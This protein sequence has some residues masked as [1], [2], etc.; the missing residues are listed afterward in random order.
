MALHRRGEYEYGDSQTDIREELLR[1]SDANGYI[2]EHFADARCVC[3]S[4]HFSLRIDDNEGAAVHICTACGNEHPIGDSDEYLEE[5]QL[6]ECECP[7]GS[8]AFEITVGLALYAESE[9]VRWLYVGCRC[10]N[11]GLTACYG[12]WKNE[13]LDYR[14]LLSRV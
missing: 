4:T 3:G 2:A 11:C 13:Y 10:V 12:D 1:Y 6:E 14:D 7:C 9:D 5:S 8:S